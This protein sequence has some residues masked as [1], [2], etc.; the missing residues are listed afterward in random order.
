MKYSNFDKTV[1][2]MSVVYSK[3]NYDFIIN[4]NSLVNDE[5]SLTIAPDVT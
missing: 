5:V 4:C 1:S 3:L 2:D